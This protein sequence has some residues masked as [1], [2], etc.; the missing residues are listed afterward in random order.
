MVRVRRSGAGSEGFD[1]VHEI[2]RGIDRPG[3][4]AG[5]AA[6]LL[7]GLPERQAFAD[8]VGLHELDAGVADAARRD[9]DD[10]READLV[11]RDWR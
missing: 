3:G 10:A 5:D 7:H 9:V 4:E 1:Q 8:G 6:G 11:V 2:G